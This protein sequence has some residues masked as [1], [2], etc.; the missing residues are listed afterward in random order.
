MDI[1]RN[2]SYNK[3]TV[4]SGN[5]L[6]GVE[7]GKETM[8]NRKKLLFISKRLAVMAMVCL[9]SLRILCGCTKKDELVLL[10]E[11][12]QAQLQECSAETAQ[13]SG[14]G[15]DDGQVL[16]QES[17]AVA[18]QDTEDAGWA[19]G[20]GA[21]AYI[22]EE[23]ET[24]YVHVCGAVITPGVYGLAAGSRVYE[25]VQAAGGFAENA[26]ESYV[27]QAQELPDGAKLVIPTKEEAALSSQRNMKGQVAT[28]RAEEGQT[29]DGG[30]QIG[31]V[32]QEG[33]GLTGSPQSAGAGQ[34]AADDGRININSATVEELCEIPGIGST[35]AAAIVSYREA[36]GGFNKPEDI[37]QV[38]GIKEGTYEKI[39][40]SISIE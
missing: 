27:N 4:H 31:I 30:V 36:H 34:N 15:K 37:M 16:G 24:V 9:Y 8:R 20:P 23:P 22:K 21:P 29:A 17:A 19:G 6:E 13:I 39:K 38:S 5:F 26:E 1:G 2:L 14:P 10:T 25:A 33:L 18:G 40:D 32:T 11:D 3:N 12:G 35:R 7:P 28:Q